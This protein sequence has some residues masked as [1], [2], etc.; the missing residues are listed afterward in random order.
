M[1]ICN[2]G[3]Y[4]CFVG[5]GCFSG[6]TNIVAVNLQISQHLLMD[7]SQQFCARSVF[8]HVVMKSQKRP[9][10]DTKGRIFGGPETVEIINIHPSIY[11]REE[12]II[13]KH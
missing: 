12:D 7:V 10:Q 5:L 9:G 2:S 13:V 4:T 6:C 3:D 1:V 8:R 11:T